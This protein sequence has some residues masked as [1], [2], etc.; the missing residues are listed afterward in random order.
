M[1]SAWML[2]CS[3]CNKPLIGL[4]ARACDCGGPI[5]LKYARLP[6][7]LVAE[8]QPGIWR[9]RSWLPLEGNETPI[10][11]GE[12]STPLVRLDRWS[13][14]I[15]LD[16]V[17]AKL[18]FAGPTGSFKDRGSA[19]LV[20]H[21]L[22]IGAGRIV[23]DSSGN[24]GAS[25][26][27]Y[28]ARAGL[29]CDVFAPASTPN[30]KLE[31]ITIYGAELHLVAG[32][33]E[34]VADAAIAEAGRTEAYYA[35]HN[36]SPFFVEG[37][38]SFAFELAEAFPSGGPDHVIMPVGG[39]SLYCG[40]VFGFEQLQQ[41]GIISSV[42]HFHLAQSSGCMPL[43]AAAR[44]GAAV[45][46]EVTRRPTVAG[47]I[48]IEHPDRGGLILRLLSRYAGEAVAVEDQEIL[49]MREELARLEGIFMEPTSAAAFAGLARLASAGK[50]G[51]SESVVVPITGSGLKDRDPLPG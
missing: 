21:A 10:S 41:A 28:A 2:A 51:P 38:K 30:T 17:F 13:R 25:I 37:M 31:Q 40:C 8:D 35:G 19:V 49:D 32:S 14:S 45:P 24:A 6:S 5:R 18:E 39:G 33:R 4:S 29:G 23:E 26:A 48:V 34:A 16:A 1:M 9:Y 46:L 44:A 43:V 7:D 12:G 50:I 3:L 27:A 36:S 47:G 42:P 15:G 22:A 11:L 20:S